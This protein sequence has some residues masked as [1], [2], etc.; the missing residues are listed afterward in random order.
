MR[1]REERERVRER[2]RKRD[3]GAC[4]MGKK[5]LKKIFLVFLN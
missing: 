3:R 1:E 2:Q 5:R 4:R